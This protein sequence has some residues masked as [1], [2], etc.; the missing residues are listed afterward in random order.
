MT[1]LLYDRCTK[2]AN[3]PFCHLSLSNS[4]LPFRF[5]R[6][7]SIS[8]HDSRPAVGASCLLSCLLMFGLPRRAAIP[9]ELRGKLAMYRSDR[10]QM[11]ALEERVGEQV[12]NC[13]SFSSSTLM[14]VRLNF[15]S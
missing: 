10:E 5:L 1:P 14:S 2:V 6:V 13:Q 4:Q 8:G 9:D 11:I 12:L 3:G 15:E 7:E